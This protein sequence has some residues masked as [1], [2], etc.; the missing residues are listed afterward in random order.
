MLCR[1]ILARRWCPARC[2]VVLFQSDDDA[3][4]APTVRLIDID[5]G[6]VVQSRSDDAD[7]ASNVPGQL[8]TS[9]RDSRPCNTVQ[10]V[11]TPERR[12]S[13]N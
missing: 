4:S 7:A 6:F 2:F 1:K 13:W 10:R 9:T 8:F 11:C 5:P 12:P 3:D